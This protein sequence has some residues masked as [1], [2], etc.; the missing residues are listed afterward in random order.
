MTRVGFYRV[1]AV[2]IALSLQSV[3]VSDVF[4]I[5]NDRREWGSESDFNKGTITVTGTWKDGDSSNS[6]GNN[7]SSLPSDQSF[8]IE[9]GGFAGDTVAQMSNGTLIIRGEKELDEFLEKTFP[10]AISRERYKATFVITD[11]VLPEAPAGGAGAAIVINPANLV[12]LS[13]VKRLVTDA[14]HVSISPN[15]AWVYVNKPVYFEADAVA[16][17]RQLT[18]LGQQ[19]TVHLMPVGYTWDAGDGS[20]AFDTV[21]PGG[22]W[23]D[24]EVTHTYRK[25][26]SN[27]SVGLTVEWSATF[28]VLGTT[29]PVAGTTIAS[30]ASAPFEIREAEAVLTG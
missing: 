12:T 23:P 27:V 26:R 3:G 6:D 9:A 25:A 10:D 21:S 29:Y 11:L 13:D 22:A 8:L 17:D 20:A 19:V 2:A 7:A 18:V 28:T 5:E 1:T 30:T 4:A 15:R 24:G 16:H 14:G